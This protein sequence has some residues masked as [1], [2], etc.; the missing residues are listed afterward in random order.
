MLRLKQ[1]AFFVWIEGDKFQQHAS[2]LN[3]KKFAEAG[4]VP[5]V[6]P[7]SSLDAQLASWVWSQPASQYVLHPPDFHGFWENLGHMEPGSSCTTMSSG[8]HIIYSDV[9]LEK[10]GDNVISPTWH[11][12]YLE[13]A[14]QT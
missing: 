13:N 3:S 1:K 8:S 12:P 11:S 7:A 9:L 2:M 4:L 5:A 6:L 10:I 14:N